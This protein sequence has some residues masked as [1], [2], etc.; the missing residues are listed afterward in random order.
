MHATGE[1]IL[2][3]FINNGIYG[4]TEVRWH[5]QHFRM[6]SQHPRRKGC[7]TNGNPLNITDIATL[8]DVLCHKQRAFT[9]KREK[10][11]GNK[12]G[13]AVSEAE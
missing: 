5:L 3:I 6:R 1:N 8:Q 12:K 11:N 9:C 10:A 4:M 7:E 2:I 13:R